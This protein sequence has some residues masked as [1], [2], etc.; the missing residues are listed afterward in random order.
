M[1]EQTSYSWEHSLLPTDTISFLG[2]SFLF[3]QLEVILYYA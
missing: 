1:S 3:G 2:L